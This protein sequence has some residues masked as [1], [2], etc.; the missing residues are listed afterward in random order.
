MTSSRC[1][2]PPTRPPAFRAGC[3]GA[4][5]GTA[6]VEAEEQQI[7]AGRTIDVPSCFNSGAAGWGVFQSPV[8]Y[9]S[10]RETACTRMLGCHLVP[11]R[12]HWVQEE[13]AEDTL[14]RDLPHDRAEFANE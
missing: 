4:A 9:D 10:M 12:G 7:L 8:A 1:N 5:C 14:R 6:R 13:H 3:S 11:G 2:A